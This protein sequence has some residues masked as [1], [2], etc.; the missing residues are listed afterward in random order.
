M[1]ALR[2]LLHRR[3]LDRGSLVLELPRLRLAV[4]PASGEV[5]GIARDESDPSHA[6]I[7]EFMLAANEVVAG[8]M[9]IR[10]LP[11]VSR[12]HDAPDADALEGFFHL[13]GHLEERWRSAGGARTERNLRAALE[14]VRDQP[15][16]PIVNL[17]LL[18]S[19]PHAEYR[20]EPGF[21][22]ALAVSRYCHFT[23]P[24]R[25]YPD[26][27]V[28][29]IL[30]GHLDGASRSGRK[31]REW[32][33]VLPRLAADASAAERRAEEAEREMVRL[34]LIRHL[35]GRI[36]EEMDATVVGV[37]P[38]GFFVQEPASLIDG[39]VHI[40]SLADDYYEFDAEQYLLRGKRRGREFRLG[41]RVR[42]VLAGLDAD[43]RE[44]R[45]EYA[46]NAGGGG[47]RRP[48]PKRRS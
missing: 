33:D 44:I 28:H 46:G 43:A 19:L 24:I 39:L 27:L 29:Q 36:G 25:R 11:W 10:G 26:L 16:A 32:H 21:H 22:Y 45:F 2:D 41:D 17:A 12:A 8:Y 48:N 6:L 37:H 47:V 20:A 13:L 35:A 15:W 3:R 34:R 23:S 9:E 40:S 1:A 14:R 7:E 30:D 42:V 5:A 18:R 38:F 4:D 31:R